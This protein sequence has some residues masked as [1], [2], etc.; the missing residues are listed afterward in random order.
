MGVPK[1]RGPCKH[2]DVFEEILT[3]AIASDVGASGFDCGTFF[4]DIDPEAEADTAA[5]AE[6]LMSKLGS[7]SPHHVKDQSAF[8][9]DSFLSKLR[10]AHAEALA[11]G[12]ADAAAAV[13]DAIKAEGG[14]TK[15]SAP[16][17]AVP[18]AED[19]TMK[20]EHGSLPTNTA[21]SL[22]SGPHSPPVAPSADRP[23][24][25][26]RRVN[27]RAGPASARAKLNSRISEQ[28]RCERRQKQELTANNG[29]RAAS[30]HKHTEVPRKPVCFEEVLSKGAGQEARQEG[31]L[32]SVGELGIE[33]Q[34]HR[35]EKLMD[36]SLPGSDLSA[37]PRNIVRSWA[38]GGMSG[39]RA[40]FELE[41]A[42]CQTSLAPKSVLTSFRTVAALCGVAG[43]D[44]FASGGRLWADVFSQPPSKVIRNALHS[45]CSEAAIS[46]SSITL[47]ELHLGLRALELRARH[48]H[49]VTAERL[50]VQI[51][52][53]LFKSYLEVQACQDKN[54]ARVRQCKEHGGSSLAQV[55]ASTLQLG[56]AGVEREARALPLEK[57]REV[58][59]DW[60]EC[61]AALSRMARALREDCEQ[62]KTYGIYWVLGVAPE[63]SDAELKRAYRELVLKHHP[64]KG[65]D[66]ATFQQ[67]QQ[68]YEKVVEDRKNGIRPPPPPWL[69]QASSSASTRSRSEAPD[70]RNREQ[71]PQASR[72]PDR[73]RSEGPS[74]CDPRTCGTFSSAEAAAQA[75]A[76]DAAGVASAPLAAEAL[77]K[78]EE[79]CEQ[80]LAAAECAR[81]SSE[82]AS[83]SAAVI[84][85]E[86]A[87]R[88]G[89]VADFSIIL[90]ASP[91]LISA[92]R[93]AA[94]D[95]SSAVESMKE[96]ATRLV[97]VGALVSDGER[98]EE[99]L[100]ASLLCTAQAASASR[101]AMAS[102]HLT[103]DVAETFQAIGQDLQQGDLGSD[104]AV[105]AIQLLASTAQ[106][107]SQGTA[108]AADAA[109]LVS[110]VATSALTTARCATSNRPP[111]PSRSE[112][113]SQSDV[114]NEDC[115]DA[116]QQETRYA[117]TP[118]VRQRQAGGCKSPTFTDD[119]AEKTSW[120]RSASQPR[121]QQ[122]EQSNSSSHTRPQ[123]ASTR[124][125]S[126]CARGPIE[127]L[128][129]RRLKSFKE[130]EELNNEVCNM[131][132]EMHRLLVKCPLFLPT[133]GAQQKD[134][135]FA[136]VGE[137]LQ[138]LVAAAASCPSGSTIEKILDWLPKHTAAESAICDARVGALHMA[139]VL[140]IETLASVF[141]EQ[142]LPGL[143]G[144]CPGIDKGLLDDAVKN[145]VESL[146]SWV[147]ARD[148][149]N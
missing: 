130:I 149:R 93:S 77:S 134:W 54:I 39:T 19:A 108:E 145:I 46:S 102:D 116:G 2:N 103:D 101:V 99:L 15:L 90:E 33:L 98:A 146:R 91:H 72:T 7:S 115:E 118:R 95:A 80:I 109:L 22:L 81:A 4:T 73:A 61:K 30:S 117:R 27:G 125:S 142:L 18:V 113:R 89:N 143:C 78:I 21:S 124:S 106:R 84:E 97:Q 121:E 9:I 85:A 86:A 96:V 138:Q 128:V 25:L 104:G 6:A 127:A 137:Y 34:N 13:A 70:T 122:E 51:W 94:A 66:T 88:S 105:L 45:V 100:Q 42:I 119:P 120:Q 44:A 147:L 133:V 110:Q 12:D 20:K 26:P 49:D 74:K 112:S 50:E 67:L 32:G 83:S 140:D 59:T 114:K 31:D 38:W 136:V 41:A 14:S 92:M 58:P 8:G 52:R 129:Q 62:L 17:S 1:P 16:S 64:D 69:N 57:L 65:G 148:S 11:A 131:Q 43:S 75:D 56:T 23:A 82:A 126:P 47:E 79:L 35:D 5:L 141:C 36:A 29:D 87:T 55:V 3:H 76:E 28:L 60:E 135:L 53:E 144:A 63:A 123:N 132:R 37:L 111:R 40:L 10:T 68:A 24:G 71:R 48:Y 107:G 139:A